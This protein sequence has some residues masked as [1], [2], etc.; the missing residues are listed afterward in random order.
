[1]SAAFQKN[2]TDFEKSRGDEIAKSFQIVCRL[3]CKNGH[4]ICRIGESWKVEG[5]APLKLSA[6]GIHQMIRDVGERYLKKKT[7]QITTFG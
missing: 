7:D 6:S 5:F 1:V 4:Q 3:V 2:M